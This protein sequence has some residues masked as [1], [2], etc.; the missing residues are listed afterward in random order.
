MDDHNTLVPDNFYKKQS[1]SNNEL[2]DLCKFILTLFIDFC[3]FT[4]LVIF[5]ASTAV[6][7]RTMFF[8]CEGVVWYSL[9]LIDRMHMRPKIGLPMVGS[10]Q[11]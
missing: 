3:K 10:K 2:L 11:K 6:K 5:V 1:N 9:L 4:P 8:G 7:Q